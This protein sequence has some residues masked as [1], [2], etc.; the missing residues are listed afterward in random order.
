MEAIKNLFGKGGA[1]LSDRAVKAVE[2]LELLSSKPLTD[3]DQLDSQ[4]LK[5][6]EAVQFVFSTKVGVVA[7]VEHGWGFSMKK[8][9]TNPDGTAQWSAPA[10]T[11]FMLASAG[12]QIGGQESSSLACLNTQKAVA[13]LLEKGFVPFVG[14]SMNLTLFAIPALTD[15]SLISGVN[16]NLI[17]TDLDVMTFSFSKGLMVDWSLAGGGVRYDAKKNAEVYGKEVTPAEVLS[18]SVPVPPEF[19]PV[20]QKLNQLLVGGIRRRI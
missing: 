11:T 3:L 17:P 4:F 20:V 10:F 8:L 5:T 2:T 18:G 9:G 14:E 7:A 19:D 1:K 6:A 16:F 13:E 15:G 12:A